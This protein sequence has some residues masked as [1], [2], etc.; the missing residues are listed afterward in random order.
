M[1]AK[2]VLAMLIASAMIMGTSVTAFGSNTTYTDAARVM[3]LENDNL[4]VTA[5]QII[6]YNPAGY[7]EAV[8]PGSIDTNGTTTDGKAILDPTSE[9]IEELASQENLSKLKTV[10]TF[11]A[12]KTTTEV[13]DYKCENLAPGAWMIIVTGSDQYL[14]NPAIIS[15]NVTSDGTKYG[16]LNYAADEWNPV[17]YPKRSEPKITKTA[18]KADAGDTD[19]VGVQR[20]DV[21]KF[22]L[23]ADIPDYSADVEGVDQYIIKDTLDG[24]SLVQSE[25]YPV[26]VTMSDGSEIDSDVETIIKGAIIN[27]EADFSADL[28]EQDTFLLQNGGKKIVITYYA[29]VT[30]TEKINVD[31]LNN[32]AELSYSTRGGVAKK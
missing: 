11:T 27:D 19:I 25:Q 7:Y 10:E 4:T 2:K 13:G 17:A 26:T 23:E 9:N 3:N 22:T 24:L 32:T 20:N 28:S 21:L 30:S 16:E 8:I 1:K 31:E 14:Y 15:V 29:K 12:D 6:K 18:E 5:Y